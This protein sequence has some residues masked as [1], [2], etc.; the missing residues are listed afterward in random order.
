MPGEVRAEIGWQRA[1]VDHDIPSALIARAQRNGG[2]MRVRVPLPGRFWLITDSDLIDRVLRTSAAEFDK[3]GSIY[4]IIRNAT[5]DEGLFVVN[6]PQTWRIL[7]EH[8]NP[9][10]TASKLTPLAH[11]SVR[12]LLDRIDGW[13]PDRAVDVFT[14]FKLLNVELLALHLFGQAVDCAAL[15]RL[16]Q[17]IFDSQRKQWFRIGGGK[18]RRAIA[19][20][21][22]E[23]HSIIDRRRALDTCDG[24][25]LGQLL[26]VRPKLPAQRIRDQVVSHLLAGFDSTACAQAWACVRLADNPAELAELRTE[27]ED[28]LGSRAPT[29]ADLPRLPLLTSFFA[30]V[31]AQRP[32]FPLIFR[33]AAI[34]TALAGRPLH[35]G[36]QLFIALGPARL[37][38][39][40]GK[41]KCI[42]EPLALL[43]GTL[44]IAV[45][46]QRFSQWQRTRPGNQQ[47]RY[48]T[49][50][51]PRHS[52]IHFRP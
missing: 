34:D 2:I 30:D 24:D 11:E 48:A 5:G 52:E 8:T 41:R 38:F 37:P 1:I 47:V 32:S 46:V 45:L 19:A 7:R 27:I 35:P 50:A 10:F 13:N 16:A 4:R 29:P 44:S 18:Y 43:T 23:V 42:G 20:M 39:G 6:D 12:R 51:P 40:T 22:T 49:T 3:G 9:A 26:Q 33:H 14:E 21:D 15:V 28:V 17:P 31:V 36:D 25:L